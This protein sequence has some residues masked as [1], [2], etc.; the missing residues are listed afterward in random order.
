MGATERPIG[1]FDSG[2]GGLTVLRAIRARL[3]GESLLYVGD[4]ARVP[5]GP[6]G[7]ALVTS[8]ATQIADALVEAGCKAIVI[9]CNTA[10]AAAVDVVRARASVPVIDVIRPMAAAVHANAAWRRIAVLATQTTVT[11]RAY[12]RAFHDLGPGYIVEQNAAPLF[13]PLAEE[14]WTEGLVPLEAARKYLAP[15]LRYG[16]VDALVLGC[17]HYPLLTQVVREAMTKEL[18]HAPPILESGEV[19]AESLAMELEREGLLAPD[20]RPGAVRY[21]V[22]DAPERFAALGERF[23]GEPLRDVE[24]LPLRVLESKGIF[25][26]KATH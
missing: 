1:L 4:S 2:V 15:V 11:S 19:V 14:G 7:A 12:P 25:S 22:T 26:A 21:R 18:G 17:T 8:Y 9:A 10:S 16:P 3:P 5:W 13:V 20:D 23:L 24:L 6:K